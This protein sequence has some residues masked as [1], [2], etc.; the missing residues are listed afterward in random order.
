MMNTIWAVVRDGKIV[1]L[2]AVQ[3]PEGTRALVTLISEDDAGFWLAASEAS[4]NEVWDNAE[5]DIYAE[6]LEK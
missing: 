5:D 4:L 1:P 2:E 6:L 3:V